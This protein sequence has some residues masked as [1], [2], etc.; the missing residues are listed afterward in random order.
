MEMVKIGKLNLVETQFNNIYMSWYVYIYMQIH[1]HAYI[2][3]H[4][5]HG[6]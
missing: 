6:L 1:T 3:M 5:K 4:T 2:Y